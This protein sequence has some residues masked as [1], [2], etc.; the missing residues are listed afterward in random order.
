VGDREATTDYGLRSTVR[1]SASTRSKR[2]L[3]CM[4]R[5]ILVFVRAKDVL[6]VAGCNLGAVSERSDNMLDRGVRWTDGT[7]VATPSKRALFF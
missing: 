5:S 3:F 6:V 1:S 7:S 4:D 2:A